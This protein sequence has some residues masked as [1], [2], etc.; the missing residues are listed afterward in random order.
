[1]KRKGFSKWFAA[2]GMLLAMLLALTISTFAGDGIDFYFDSQ[3]YGK[4][5][6]VISTSFMPG[7]LL[8]NAF[9]MDYNPTAPGCRF[10]AWSLSPN[11]DMWAGD[12]VLTTP[13]GGTLR[14][15]ARWDVSDVTYRF[16]GNGATGGAI[17]DILCAG[18]KSIT[19]PSG[20]AFTRP[21]YSFRNWTT[22]ADG[23]GT[24][25]NAGQ[26][27]TFDM[28]QIPVETVTH[29]VITLYAQWNGTGPVIPTPSQFTPASNIIYLTGVNRNSRKLVLRWQP[30]AGASGYEVTVKCHGK[31]DVYE[32]TNT[33]LRVTNVRGMSIRN[34]TV[35]YKIRAYQLMNGYK[36]YIARSA[37]GISY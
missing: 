26:S 15:Y 27:I 7:D 10:R 4:D 8:P 16:H 24:A 25:Y 9:L 31:K 29:D 36:Y 21:G 14:L 12:K 20:A 3:G 1:M 30:V 35:K 6:G 2:A 11:S 33:K 34:K 19:L 13:K 37:Q 22:N 28:S 32:V 5:I 23:T 18:G 17:N